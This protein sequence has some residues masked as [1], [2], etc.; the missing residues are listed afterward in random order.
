MEEMSRDEM[1][2]YEINYYLDNYNYSDKAGA[3][4]IQEWIGMIGDERIEGDFYNVMGLPIA[5]LYEEIISL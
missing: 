1:I 4:R 5:R 2:N 3:Y